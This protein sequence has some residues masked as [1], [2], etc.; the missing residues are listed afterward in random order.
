MITLLRPMLVTLALT[1]A[2]AFAQEVVPLWPPG[3]PGSETRKVE[4]EKVDGDRVS[5]IHHPSLAVYLPSKDRATGTAIIVIPGGG[6]RF[7]VMKHEGHHLGER[8]AARLFPHQTIQHNHAY[9]AHQARRVCHP[10][11]QFGFPG[12]RHGCERVVE[13]IPTKHLCFN[14]VADERT[15]GEPRGR[16]EAHQTE[17]LA[18]THAVDRFLGGGESVAPKGGAVP[19]TVLRLNRTVRASR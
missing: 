5:H 11:I 17:Y 4:P 18:E 12:H 14:A 10:G 13:G 15:I 3:A 6:H 9:A 8:L 19:F 2:T 7:L 16:G 1:A